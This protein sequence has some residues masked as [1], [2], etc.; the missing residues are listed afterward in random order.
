MSRA[1]ARAGAL[2]ELGRAAE[3]AALLREA[4]A[5]DPEDAGLHAQ[6][7]R[8]LGV[9]GDRL[10]QQRGRLARAAELEQR[11]GA[12]RGTAHDRRCSL[13]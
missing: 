2:L 6:L 13:M 5:S 9:G 8:V 11:V 3:A 1:A 4:I 10:A 12:S 7:A